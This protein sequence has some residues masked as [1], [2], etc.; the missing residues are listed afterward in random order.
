MGTPTPSHGC[1]CASTQDVLIAEKVVDG[2][3]DGGGVDV[4]YST[5]DFP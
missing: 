1:V 3:S 4:H 5:I 2:G